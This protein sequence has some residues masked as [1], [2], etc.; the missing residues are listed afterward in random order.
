M[1]NEEDICNS[2]NN[3]KHLFNEN[4]DYYEDKITHKESIIEDIKRDTYYAEKS[5]KNKIRIIHKGSPFKSITEDT[6][7][8][9]YCVEKMKKLS[10]SDIKNIKEKLVKFKNALFNNHKI[11]KDPNECN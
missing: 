9:I 4:K 11:K 8:G 2:I 6:E 5:K 3:I 7:R 1:F 10:K